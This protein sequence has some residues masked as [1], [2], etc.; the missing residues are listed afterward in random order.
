ML[1]MRDITVAK[2][3]EM[4]DRAITKLQ[5]FQDDEE[6]FSYCK[7][8]SV[9]KYTSAIVGPNIRAMHTML[10]NKPP[11]TG[12]GSSRHPPHQDLWYFPFRPI[13]RIVACWTA[14]QKMDQTN[15]CLEVEP[16]SHKGDFFYHSYPNDGVVNRAYHGIHGYKS[17]KSMLALEM[18]AGDSV[19]FHPLLVHGSGPNNSDRTRKVQKN[20]INFNFMTFFIASNIFYARPYHAI[21]RQRLASTLTSRAQYRMT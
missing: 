2:K 18:A 7:H 17:E 16:G 5:K 10:I 20:V 8:P 3:K 13:N 4:G 14:L 21:M 15:G 19:F 1:M 9:L 6:L 12:L 11:D